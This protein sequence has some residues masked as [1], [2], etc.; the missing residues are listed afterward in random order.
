MKNT[1]KEMT[2]EDLAIMVQNGFTETNG[3]IDNV[4]NELKEEINT[5]REEENDHF[6]T[7]KNILYRAHDNR[8]EKIEDDVRMLKTAMKM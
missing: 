6:A 4:K 8:I 3:R 1:R 7:V 2:M 5:L